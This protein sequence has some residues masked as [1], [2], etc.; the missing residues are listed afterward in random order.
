MQTCE[1]CQHWNFDERDAEFD[2]LKIGRCAA[3]R[4]REDVISPARELEDWDAREAEE[5]R[6][7]SEAKA[8]AVDGSGYYAAIRTAPDFGC[9]LHEPKS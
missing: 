8:I 6:L 2:G 4:Q 1:T 5:R 3:I 7:L 9:T